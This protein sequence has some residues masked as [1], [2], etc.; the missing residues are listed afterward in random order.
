[1]RV[2]VNFFPTAESIDVTELGMELEARGFDSIF[3]AEHSHIPSSRVTPWGGRQDA[4]P[5]PEYY[6]QTFD[7]FGVLHAIAAVTN[8]LVLGTGIALVAQR[9]PIWLAKQVATI[10]HLSGGR[11]VFGVGYGWNKEELASHGV[12]YA[13]RRDVVAERIGLMKALWTQDEASFSGVHE[14]LE[15]SWAW[16]KPLQRPHPPIIVGSA[17]GPRTFR[18][19]V[20]W[21]DGW[22]PIVGRGE[23]AERV[24]GLHRHLEEAGRDP[25]SF[26]LSV[27]AAPPDPQ[28]WESLAELGFTRVLMHL[29]SAP[30]DDVLRW[31]DE[32]TPLIGA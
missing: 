6:A 1:M 12:A 10:D 21:A 17:A 29:P 31:L 16:P 30:R 18:D 3:L 27:Y 32:R 22:M 8:R 26:E 20:A 15:P 23:I 19:M 24:A 11:F 28:L 14:T 25:G 9:D 5:L 7:A 4:P 2:G 13:D